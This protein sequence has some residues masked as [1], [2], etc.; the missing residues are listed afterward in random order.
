MATAVITSIQELAQHLLEE[1]DGNY[2]EVMKL[3]TGNGMRRLAIS[4]NA[5][6]YSCFC[7]KFLRNRR[8]YPKFRTYIKRCHTR[9]ALLKIIDGQREGL[10]VERLLDFIESWF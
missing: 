4:K 7:K 9:H 2:L 1:L 6:W 8:R 3:D 10:Y 5:E